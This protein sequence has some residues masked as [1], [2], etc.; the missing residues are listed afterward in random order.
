MKND[1]ITVYNNKNEKKD[2]KLLMVIEKEYKYIIYTDIDNHDIYHNLYVAKTNS[3]SN[4]NNT[5][6]ISPEEWTIV[7]NEYQKIINSKNI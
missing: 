2:Y 4:I 7:E 6:S 1:I 3:L 5:L